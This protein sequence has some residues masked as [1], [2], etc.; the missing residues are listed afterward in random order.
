MDQV[1]NASMAR[2]QGVALLL[3]IFAGVALTPAAIGIYS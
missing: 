3:E 1:I 2:R